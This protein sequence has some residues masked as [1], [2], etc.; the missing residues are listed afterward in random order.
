MVNNGRHK[1]AV[2]TRMFSVCHSHSPK[3]T[4]HDSITM[5]FSLF[6]LTAIF[7]TASALGTPNPSPEGYGT[8]NACTKP[9][10]MIDDTPTSLEVMLI[11]DRY[12][13]WSVPG[14]LLYQ[15][16]CWKKPDLRLNFG[17]ALVASPGKEV[18]VGIWTGKTDVLLVHSFMFQHY[19]YGIFSGLRFYRHGKSK[20][21]YNVEVV[22]FRGRKQ[23]FSSPASS[24]SY[25]TFVSHP[26]FL[27]ATQA[28]LSA[29]CIFYRLAP[30]A[31][32]TWPRC[33]TRNDRMSIASRTGL[34]GGRSRLGFNTVSP[35]TRAF[36]YTTNPD[37]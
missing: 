1:T 36:L 30:P 26:L 14:E 28:G 18:A 22:G 10:G 34:S 21:E 25:S 16:V 23:T 3:T 33:S 6:A 9:G 11:Q 29:E 12:C 15:E 5:K 8:V 19:R 35:I 13:G 37:V 2:R 17:I 4:I 31:H 20:K 32:M 7:A 27:L 24:A